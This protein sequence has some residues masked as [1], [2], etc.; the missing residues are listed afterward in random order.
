MPVFNMLLGHF[1]GDYL[2]QNEWMALN[3]S[4]SGSFWP[5][6]VHAVIYSITICVFMLDHRLSWLLVVFLSHYPVD[7]W[8]LAEGWLK[9]ING[10]TLEG[11]M[12]YGHH[13]LQSL[14]PKHEIKNEVDSLIHKS[15]VPDMEENY[16]ILR[17]SFHALV[18]AVTDNTIH[19]LLMWSGWYLLKYIGL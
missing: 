1:V 12:R 5:G 9:L 2:L 7:R 13:R 10:R 8:S 18:Y 6:F 4:R 15:T 16:R 11:F 14:P 3:K 19:I 17:G